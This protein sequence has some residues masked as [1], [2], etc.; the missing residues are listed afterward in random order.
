MALN[1]QST[2]TAIR[3]KLLILKW[4]IILWTFSILCSSYTYTMKTSIL[5]SSSY[6]KNFHK[7]VS[8]RYDHISNK[9]HMFAL[10]SCNFQFFSINCRQKSMFSMLNQQFYHDM[11]YSKLLS[12]VSKQQLTSTSSLSMSTHITSNHQS[13]T[14]KSL[15]S[16]ESS[17][18]TNIKS[19]KKKINNEDNKLMKS[20]RVV[21][22]KSMKSA[23]KNQRLESP[24]RVT[25]IKP[26]I[27]SNASE[28]TKLGLLSN[29]I[30]A[31]TEMK[32][33][34]PTP[35]QKVMIPRLLSHESIV[36]AASTG[37]GKTLAFVLPV[38]QQLL[39]QVLIDFNI[40]H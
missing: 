10:N 34:K 3:D 24:D 2:V 26:S 4:V 25:E 21:S 17:E 5:H 33:I 19:S 13:E 11:K 20:L 30:N 22:G 1:I 15:K 8:G 6:S 23:M 35:V 40:Y 37:S 36:M 39:V 32:F 12:S 31:L 9:Q 29:I 18:K 14:S 38:L 7:V 16:S 27:D 28:F